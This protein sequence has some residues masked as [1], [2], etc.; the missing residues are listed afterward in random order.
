MLSIKID[1]GLFGIFVLGLIYGGCAGIVISS[2]Q[3]NKYLA[4]VA[5]FVV[6][7]FFHLL[8]LGYSF[9]SSEN[10]TYVVL[11]LL[12]STLAGLITELIIEK[13]IK[14]KA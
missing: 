8:F 10:F 13:I 9:S 7:L 1:F 3:L 4:V 6:T 2:L 11:T 14:V 5:S 12:G